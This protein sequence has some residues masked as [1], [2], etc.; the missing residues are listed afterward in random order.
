MAGKAAANGAG[1]LL[2]RGLK[3][4]WSHPVSAR[5]RGGVVA[6]M[7]L[8]SIAALASYHAEDPSWNTATAERARNL[9][10][11]FGAKLADLDLQ[12][13][14]LAA[15]ILAAL[16]VISGL[17][18]AAHRAPH[19]ARGRLRLRA[20]I[21]VLGVLALAGVLEAPPPPA[22]WP[23][24]EGLGGLWG[25]GVL[26]LA[27]GLFRFARLPD[28]DWIAAGLL[29]IAAIGALAAAIG[30]GRRDLAGLAD[31]VVAMTQGLA[32]RPPANRRSSS[33][34][35]AAARLARP[36]PPIR[37]PTMRPSPSSAAGR[38]P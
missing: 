15:W 36:A 21:G 17:S 37:T 31:G 3:A 25:A 35:P 38:R 1:V 26:S 11:D 9:L 16:M 5:F 14:G 23:L 29:A 4:G 6:V 8:A 18:R 22:V 10:G 34:R 32:R 28:A 2:L 7:G 30:M 20:V 27:A 24:A 12:S 13:F 19:A 33:R